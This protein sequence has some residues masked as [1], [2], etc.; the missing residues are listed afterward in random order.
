MIGLKPGS[1]P[2]CFT[3]AG[4]AGL[5][6]GWAAMV[7]VAGG[8]GLGAGSVTTGI[9]VAGAGVSMGASTGGGS[10]TWDIFCSKAAR[11]AAWSELSED[12]GAT[13]FELSGG[14]DIV[15]AGSGV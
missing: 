9:V 15:A 6:G 2:A 5:T 13:G 4:L 11:A 1:F 8:A 12:A 10:C 14:G 7:F 3:S